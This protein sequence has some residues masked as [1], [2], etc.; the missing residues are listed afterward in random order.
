MVAPMLVAGLRPVWS[1][2][3]WDDEERALVRETLDFLHETLGAPRV[4]IGQDQRANRAGLQRFASWFQAEVKKPAVLSAMIYTLDYGPFRGLDDPAA[5][6]PLVNPQARRFG[7]G[8]E[9]RVGAAQ[10]RPVLR[11]ARAGK[12]LW[13]RVLSVEGAPVPVEVTLL[14][15][16]P[17]RLGEFGWKLHLLCEGEYCHVYV[18]PQ[19]E[20]LFFFVSW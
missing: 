11:C 6:T 12:E 9:L 10:G 14:D 19:G 3:S 15:R 17:D 5:G 4:E 1:K 7:D 2:D 13:S 18:D 20:L 16:E 8:F